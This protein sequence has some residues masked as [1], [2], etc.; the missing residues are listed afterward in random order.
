VIE[1][2]SAAVWLDPMEGGTS[3]RAIGAE[4]VARIDT[5]N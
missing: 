1:S 3:D 5:L 2:S 4:E